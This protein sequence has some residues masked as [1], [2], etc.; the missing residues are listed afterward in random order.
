MGPGFPPQYPSLFVSLAT[1]RSKIS[2]SL[3]RYRKRHPSLVA[4]LEKQASPDTHFTIH[5]NLSR[6]TIITSERKQSSSAGD[7]KKKCTHAHCFFRPVG[8]SELLRNA[9]CMPLDVPALARGSSNSQ[10]LAMFYQ[11]YI[12]SCPKNFVAL[13][14]RKSDAEASPASSSTGRMYCSSHYFPLVGILS[15]V[16]RQEL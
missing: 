12:I 9:R 1:I 4:A 15:F 2:M 6:F 13:R 10:Q 5:I 11:F 7:S 16:R 8:S 3:F 14:S